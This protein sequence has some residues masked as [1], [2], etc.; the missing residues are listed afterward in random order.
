MSRHLPVCGLRRRE[1]PGEES[2]VVNCP[3]CSFPIPTECRNDF[4]Y[5][6]PT[7]RESFRVDLKAKPGRRIVRCGPRRDGPAQ[8]ARE[9]PRDDENF[10]EWLYR[11]TR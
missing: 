3:Y 6:C 10:R 7:C 8:H 4:D 11:V 9:I 5:A 1:L 2:A